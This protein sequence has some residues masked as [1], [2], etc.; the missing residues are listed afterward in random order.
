MRK[1]SKLLVGMDV[2]KDSIDVATGDE[3]GGEVRHFGAVGGD[4][5]AVLRLVRKLEAT[6][7]A[8]VFVYE[9]GPCGFG[10]YRL[11][12]GRGHE[13]WVVSPG[14]TRRSNADRVKTDRRDCPKLCRLARAGELSAIYIPDE[15]GKRVERIETAIRA[16]LPQWR[17]QPVVE[18]LQAFRGI[19][20]IPAVRLGAE[21]GELSRFTSVR[22][23]MGYLGRVPSENSTGAHRNP[24]TPTTRSTPPNPTTRPDRRRGAL[25]VGE[26]S[27]ERY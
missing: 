7:K 8:L 17:W 27:S 24:R 13:C 23:L 4:R 19:R 12:R 6:G 18:A 2:H 20:A 5:A 10:I 11:L 25:A 3:G 14:L 9:A 26:P 21:L 16:E 15:A 22:H 1:S